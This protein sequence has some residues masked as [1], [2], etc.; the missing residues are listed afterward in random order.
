MATTSPTDT[1]PPGRPAAP[2]ARPAASPSPT[3]RAVRAMRR[4]K[5]AVAGLAILVIWLLI[6]AAAPI[7]APYDPLQDQNLKARLQPPSLQYPFGTDDLGRD[8]FK[9]VIHGA[10]ISIPA[11]IVVV[12]AA[13]AIGVTYGAMAG[14]AGGLTDNILMRLTDLMLAFPLIVLALAI[15]AVLGPSLRNAAIAAIIVTWA[16]YARIT[17]GQI[18]SIKNQEYVGAANAIGVPGPR[19]MW[20]HILPNAQAPLLVKVTTDIGAV[21][22]LIAGLSF[23]GLG[24]PPPSPEWGA[25]IA[26]ARPKFSAAWWTGT[27]PGLAILTVVM[28]F[29]FLGDGLRDAFDPRGQSH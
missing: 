3:R 14:Y 13:A 4:N 6:A 9:R 16:E 28:A 8:V 1:T 27:F 20:R 24:D 10:R 5:T 7:I 25:M 29:N 12:L 2:L 17:R 22:L 21:I 18:L 19:V 15:A 26:L 11:G 23:L